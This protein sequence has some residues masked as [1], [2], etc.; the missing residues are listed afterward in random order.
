MRIVI[1]CDA[2]GEYG[3]GHVTRCLALASEL[4]RSLLCPFEDIL[5]VSTT[6]WMRALSKP[7]ACALASSDSPFL[8]QKDDCAVFDTP[9]LDWG[10]DPRFLR[11]LRQREVTVVRLDAPQAPQETYDLLV[12]PNAHQPR[13][14]ERRLRTRPPGTVCLG[15]EYVML[16]PGATLYGPREDTPEGR[17][18]LVFTT[19]G[20]DPRDLLVGLWDACREFF[21]G[22]NKRFLVGAGYQGRLKE[23]AWGPD[24]EVLPFRSAHLRAA[25]AVVTLLGQTCY[26]LLYWRVPFVVVGDTPE[27]TEAALALS[28]RSPPRCFDPAAHPPGLAAF[29]G[30]C[31]GLLQSTKFTQAFDAW[32]SPLDAEGVSR[33]A[34][35]VL[36]CY[37]DD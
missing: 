2:G 17:R 6:P 16:T 23:G 10:T 30:W 29:P 20:S 26:E 36:R 32:P 19:G 27:H 11:G 33:V 37:F 5:F 14:V 28:Q 24:W 18:T 8:Y 35:A 31:E 25:T 13:E 9:A 3:L 4:Q 21:P 7:F 1:R 22:W 34:E 12:V 15:W